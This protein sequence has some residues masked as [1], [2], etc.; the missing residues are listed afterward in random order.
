MMI[1]S[2]RD[3]LRTAAAALVVLVVAG[4]GGGSSSG[5]PASPAP[6]PTT[7]IRTAAVCEAWVDSDAAGAKVLLG[8]DLRTATPE[9]VQ[10]TIKEFWSKQEPILASIE[11]QAPDQIRSDV[12]KL[13]QLA[14]Q[15]ATNGD[16]GTV[17]GPALATADRGVDEFMLRECGYQHVRVTATDHAYQGLPS[18][19]APGTVA[20]T[21]TNQ[22]R[23]EHQGVVIRINDEVT[24]PFAEILGLPPEQQR[25][26]L[27]AVNSTDADPGQTSTVFVR[28]TAGRYGFVD[29]LPQGSTSITALG[30]GPPHFTLG[31]V[32]EFT[33]A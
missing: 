28:L 26:M 14:R 32:G 23:E 19:V 6:A 12:T 33:V 1:T 15:G 7:A 24:Q 29:V 3:G 18:S 9:Q 4:C 8:L 20:F 22:G 11:Q 10:S 30:S 16:I 25:S 13:R 17:V 2:P 31:M 5:A 27:K 21:L